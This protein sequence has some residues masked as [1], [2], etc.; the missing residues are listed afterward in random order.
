MNEA[1][2]ACGGDEWRAVM[3][4]HI[5]PWAM[6]EVDLG[7]DVL[8]VGPGYGATT[9]IL[10]E[11]APSL[12]SVE[13]DEELAA[14]LTERFAAKDNVAIVVGD[15]T[16][17]GYPDGRFS[18]AACFTMLHHVPTI[19]LQDRLFAEVAR[20]LRPGAALVASDSL[21]SDELAA[22]HEDDTYNPV[23]PTSL[24]ARLEAAGFSEVEVRTNPFG[25]AAVARR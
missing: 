22:H 5:L 21:A 11:K 9:D 7:D 19:E 18:G 1:H 25:W 20:V 16:A 2:Q 4:E 6:G 13:I 3:R 10:C 17:L 15:A 23:D 24:P 8:E 14:M 12:T